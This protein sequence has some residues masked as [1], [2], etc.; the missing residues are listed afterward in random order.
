MLLHASHAQTQN[1]QTKI[2]FVKIV[3]RYAL[4]VQV[5]QSV[6]HV[7]QDIISH[8]KHVKSALRLVKLVKPQQ[9][10]AYLVSVDT[11]IQQINVLS[12]RQDVKLVP[13]Q[14]QIV[15]LALTDTY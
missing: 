4:F 8:H 1:I 5:Q 9:Q 2:T 13:I 14:L 15:N 10:H 3:L 11:I 6:N 7:Y 12:V